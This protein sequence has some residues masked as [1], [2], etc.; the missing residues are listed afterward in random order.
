MEKR[1][2]TT[3]QYGTDCISALC[4]GHRMAGT[5]VPVTYGIYGLFKYTYRIS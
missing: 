4:M 2:V 3:Y 1:T 5:V